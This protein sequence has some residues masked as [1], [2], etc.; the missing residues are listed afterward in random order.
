L[1]TVVAEFNRHNQRQLRVADPQTAR[2]LVGGS[3]RENDVEGFLAA[4]ALTHGVSAM[5]GGPA[6]EVITLSGGNASPAR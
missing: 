6:G 4:L 3:F 1:E 5:P 2:L